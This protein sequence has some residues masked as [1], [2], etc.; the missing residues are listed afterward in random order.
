MN[1]IKIKSVN[2]S[3]NFKF[4]GNENLLDTQR[5]RFV[6]YCLSQDNYEILI[7]KYCCNKRLNVINQL[8]LVNER[9][10]KW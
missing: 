8:E 2:L 9:E 3:H 4:S 1:L 7:Y 5:N 10:E 6:S